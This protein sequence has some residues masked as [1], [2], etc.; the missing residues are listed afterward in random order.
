MNT[1]TILYATALAALAAIAV[2]AAVHA[3][4]CP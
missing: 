2:P 1:R 4:F 3:S